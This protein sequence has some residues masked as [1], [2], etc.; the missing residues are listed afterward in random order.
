MRIRD[1]MSRART[2]AGRVGSH[3]GKEKVG[4]SVD[5]QSSEKGEPASRQSW[6]ELWRS[7]WVLA[8]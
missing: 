7:C 1:T 5:Q 3:I 2:S 4:E 8:S 6:L